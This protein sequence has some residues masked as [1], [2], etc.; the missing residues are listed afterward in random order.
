MTKTATFTVMHFSIAFTVVYLMTE[1]SRR[2]R[3]CSRSAT[4]ALEWRDD[5]LHTAQ[6]EQP[7]QGATMVAEASK[8]G[9]SRGAACC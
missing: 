8:T 7:L 3:H 4:A 5:L 1:P 6:P 9:K 2:R